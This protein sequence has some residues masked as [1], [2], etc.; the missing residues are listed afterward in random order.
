[1]A[2][3]MSGFVMADESDVF[4]TQ[5]D[6][7][8]AAEHALRTGQLTDFQRLM[9][10]LSTYPLYPYL[11]LE[12]MRRQLSR[13]PAEKIDAFLKD[14]ANSPLEKQ[15]RHAWLTSLAQQNKWEQYLEFYRPTNNTE[16][17]CQ[18]RW[19]LLK[20]GRTKQAYVNIEHL[21]LVGYSQP[22][23]CDRIFKAWYTDG[24]MTQD[25]IW[26]RIQL[27][28]DKHKLILARYLIR[29][30]TPGNQQWTR[31]WIK[32]Y[33]N[34]SLILTD[35]GFA[36]GHPMRNA[37]LL[38]GIKRIAQSDP[39]QAINIWENT[40]HH[41]YTFN[42][43]E[44]AALDRY[45]AI[46]LA[47]RGRPEALSWLAVIDPDVEDDQ[48]REWRVRSA[49]SQ[50]NWDAVLAWISLL[51]ADQQ[52][53][54]R[55]QYWRARA[56][57][58]QQQ[59]NLAEEIYFSL[60]QTRSYYGFLSADRVE[61]PYRLNAAPL[62]VNQ[63]DL[64]A[65]EQNPGIQ[66]ARELYLLDRIIDAR[67][68]WYYATYTMTEQQLSQAAKLA[69]NWGWHD[70]AILTIA[71]TQ[72][73]DDLELRFPLVH[74]DQI[75]SQAKINHIDPAFA[76]AIIR[77][78]SAF[79]IDARSHAGALGLMQ[80][81]PHTAKQLAKGLDIEINHT[82]DIL[83]VSNNLQF[84]MNYLRKALNRYD[85]NPVLASAAYNAGPYRVKKW[86]PEKGI[87]AS[88]LWTETLPI[89][90]TRNYIENIMA[91]TAIYEQRMGR[92]PTPLTVRM[93]PITAPNTSLSANSASSHPNETS[94]STSLSYSLQD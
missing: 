33:S 28:M 90:E 85:N 8:L 22:R 9:D 91:Y 74:Q 25:L 27:A 32:V 15:L 77:Q 42:E 76:Y 52:Q 37:I 39:L 63:E 34:P 4:V 58:K 1:M 3:L 14:Y 23:V 7:F 35:E 70:R 59:D 65:I 20:T 71:R 66:R 64:S 51:G 80:V 94:R 13:I 61:A 29:F 21:W 79:T 57:E 45:L 55:W 41:R 2:V 88:D 54:Y 16:L 38:Y 62:Q 93:P 67:R 44:L 12:N 31:L 17:Q 82:F 43:S 53:S 18:Y 50:E 36:S 92:Q 46:V 10:S 47:V 75:L 68:E 56:L 60:A 73:S 11:Q 24:G 81:M 40:I 69:Q 26:N 6:D 78:E 83:D 48:L 86:L 89:S 5:R 49:L 84:G 72:Y 30:Q 87:V 19:A